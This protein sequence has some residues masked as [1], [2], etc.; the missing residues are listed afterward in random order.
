MT[1]NL[2]K[3]SPVKPHLPKKK[4][5]ISSDGLFSREVTTHFPSPEAKVPDTK[6]RFLHRDT[7]SDTFMPNAIYSEKHL[8]EG[9]KRIVFAFK[10]GKN[11]KW[12]HLHATL[13]R[14]GDVISAK[15]NI[16]MPFGPNKAILGAQDIMAQRNSVLGG[17]AS[18]DRKF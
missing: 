5:D 6:I 3:A 13:D 14:L 10:D 4:L 18:C 9:G 1:I 15:G 12:E 8:P 7:P 16:P 2:V 11:K 17:V